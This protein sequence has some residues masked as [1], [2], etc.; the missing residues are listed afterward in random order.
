[1]VEW[2]VLCRRLEDLGHREFD[3]QNARDSVLRDLGDEC[4]HRDPGEVEDPAN[5]A[6]FGDDGAEHVTRAARVCQITLS[7]LATNVNLDIQSGF[8]PV[9]LEKRTVTGSM[10]QGGGRLHDSV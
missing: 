7:E 3:A 5:R 10:P 2:A 8:I 9:R 4:R 1:M 6:G